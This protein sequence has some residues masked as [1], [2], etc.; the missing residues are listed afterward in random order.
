[1]ADLHV[2]HRTVHVSQSI[3]ELG[4]VEVIWLVTALSAAFLGYEW[5]FG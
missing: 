1:M 3:I 5:F 2:G 4:L